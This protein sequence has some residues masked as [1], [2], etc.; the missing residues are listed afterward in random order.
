MAQ[1]AA[2]RE[3]ERFRTPNRSARRL[4]RL[5]PPAND[6]RRPGGGTRRLWL[7]AGLAGVAALTLILV[8]V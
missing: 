1:K 5:G 8:F 2:P 7:F 6:N 4:I 3:V